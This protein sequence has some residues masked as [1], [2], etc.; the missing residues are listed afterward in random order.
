[1][2]PSGTSITG[3]L[4]LLS[5]L[6]L[7]CPRAIGA[8]DHTLELARAL[9]RDGRHADAAIEFRRLAL[10]ET[11]DVNRASYYWAAA[12]EYAKAG[13]LELSD[14]ML[15][16]AE[17]NSPALGPEAL[18]LR[19]ANAATSQNWRE[20][21]FYFESLTQGSTGAVARVANLQLATA[22]LRQ[23]DIEGA[24]SALNA[25]PEN[26]RTVAALDA[27]AQG[28]DRSPRIGGLLGLIPGLGYAYSGEYA[29]AARSLILN[30]IFLFGAVKTAE[31]E[32]WGACTVISFFELTWYSGSIYGGVDA[33]HRY[34]RDR[35]DRCVDATGG[36]SQATPNYAIL[37]ILSLQYRF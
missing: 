9:S 16:L 26:T 27:Y 4:T 2:T 21:G 18:L 8:Q 23:H 22:R 17:N 24:R 31:N 5:V 7:A 3:L 33:A 28:S 25:T 13:N 10:D 11:S 35:L 37:P 1:M 19:G 12:Y 20:A 32:D 36:R 6:L 14:K 15:N 30:G 34:N 29:N